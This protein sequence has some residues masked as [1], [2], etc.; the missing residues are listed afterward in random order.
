MEAATREGIEMIEEDKGPLKF[1]SW[2]GK[3]NNKL[4]LA[5]ARAKIR[6][7]ERTQRQCDK[8]V[9]KAIKLLEDSLP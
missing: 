1:P 5:E 8:L 4:T 3:P 7:M 9:S 6:D 2:M